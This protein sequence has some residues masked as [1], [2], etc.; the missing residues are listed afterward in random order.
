MPFNVKATLLCELANQGWSE[1]YYTSVDALTED[2]VAARV[3]GLP[4]GQSIMQAR[5]K[6]SPYDVRF[7]GVRVSNTGRKR[8]SFFFASDTY[9]P[10]ASAGNATGPYKIYSHGLYGSSQAA[11]VYTKMPSSEVD[12]AVKVRMQNADGSNRRVLLLRGL[13]EEIIGT[14]GAYNSL[15]PR[16]LTPMLGFRG[17]LTA[18]VGGNLIRTFLPFGAGSGQVGPYT[19]ATLALAVADYHY[20]VVTV[21]SPLQIADNATPPNVRDVRPGDTLCIRGYKGG[22]RVNGDHPVYSISNDHMTV[23]LGPVRRN[24]AVSATGTPG[25]TIGA[26]YFLYNPV[27]SATDEGLYVVSRKTGRPFGLQAGLRKAR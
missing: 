16:W 2:S 24:V 23:T 13:P 1:T 22:Y 12:T 4:Y 5:A 26:K 6:L 15:T 11:N 9:Y 3:L 27:T 17:Q 25:A 18:A 10:T 19:I 14:E 7:L 8:Q 20:I 21:G